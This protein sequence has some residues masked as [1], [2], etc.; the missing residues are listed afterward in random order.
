MTT[1]QKMNA[2]AQELYNKNYEACNKQERNAA[3]HLYLERHAVKG[4]YTNKPLYK[5]F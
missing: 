4:S 3:F 2:C 1:E 5:V